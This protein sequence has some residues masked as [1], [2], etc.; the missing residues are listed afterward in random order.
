MDTYKLLVRLFNEQC[1]V[2]KTDAATSV[3]V[4]PNKDVP[5]DSLQNPSDPDAAYCGHKGKGYQ[6][7]V[8]ETYSLDKS[9]PNLITHINVEAANESDANAL[10]PAIENAGTRELAPT[11]LLADTLYGSDDNV[12]KAKE[13]GV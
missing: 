6:M 12:E 2:E 11:E 4:K 5:S 10:L 9:Q 13:L 8:M 3:V 1:V 7:Q